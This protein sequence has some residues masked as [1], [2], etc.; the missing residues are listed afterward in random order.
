MTLPAG[1]TPLGFILTADRPRALAFYTAVMGFALLG[2][3]AYGATLDMAGLTVR[4]T[5]IEGH[6]AG[7]H[8]VLGWTVPDIEAAA[9]A[10]VAKGVAFTIYPGFGQD[11][12]G[13]WS[14]PDGSVRLAWFPDPDGNMLC[15]TQRG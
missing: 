13:I 10:L 1:A 8:A 3:D 4:L 2:E 7:P 6:K 14:A 5:D 15:L 9:Q 11:A 12:N